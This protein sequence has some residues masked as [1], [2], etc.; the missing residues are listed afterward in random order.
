MRRMAY[1]RRSPMPPWST[2]GRK[3]TK[4]LTKKSTSSARKVDT[5]S[6]FGTSAEG[7]YCA[8]KATCRTTIVRIA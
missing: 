3:S 7:T 5:S 6:A 8:K 1:E 2:T 4:P